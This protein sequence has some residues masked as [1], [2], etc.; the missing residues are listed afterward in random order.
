MCAAPCSRNVM[1]KNESDAV[2]DPERKD[3]LGLIKGVTSNG[4]GHPRLS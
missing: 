4:Q 3:P 1:R 2:G